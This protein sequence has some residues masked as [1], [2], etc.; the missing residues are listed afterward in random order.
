[1][2]LRELANAGLAFL[3]SKRADTAV[4]YQEFKK[5]MQR[6]FGRPIA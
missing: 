4:S 6:Y 5:V 2:V 3:E 1:M